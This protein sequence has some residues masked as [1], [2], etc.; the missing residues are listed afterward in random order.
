MYSE[1]EKRLFIDGAVMLIIKPVSVDENSMSNYF[2]EWSP[3]IPRLVI[4]RHSRWCKYDLGHNY[5]AN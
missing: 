5:I 1:T 2:F 4:K 3:G